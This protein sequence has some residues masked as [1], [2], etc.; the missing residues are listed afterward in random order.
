MRIIR[1]VK[2]LQLLAGRSRL[3]ELTN[4]HVPIGVVFLHETKGTIVHCAAIRVLTVIR[5]TKF[6]RVVSISD[7]AR[8]NQGAAVCH[9]RL[10]DWGEYESF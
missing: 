7:E 10:G 1:T 2:L 4:P 8:S 6:I 9:D 3:H 5:A